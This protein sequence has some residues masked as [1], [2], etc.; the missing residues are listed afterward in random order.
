M[1]LSSNWSKLS[2]TQEKRVKKA[3]HGKSD[4]KSDGKTA[5]VGSRASGTPPETAQRRKS[6]AKT[7]KIMEMVAK[8]N[9][10]MANSRQNSAEKNEVQKGALEEKIS[11]D[12]AQ[13]GKAGKVGS[14][15]KFVAMD[16]EFVGVGPDGKE[17]VL[18]RV[19]VVN[20]YG[21]EVL[22]L[23]VRPKEK[24]TDWRTWV[25]GITPAHMKQA[26]TLEEAQRR[27]AAMLKNRVLIGHGL[28]HDLEMLMVSH[29]KAQIR[30]TSMHGPFRE[31]Y[32]AGKTPSLK[33]LARE[34]LN[35]DIQGKEHSSVEDA[36]AAL[37]LYKSDKVE[38]ERL[39]QQRFSRRKA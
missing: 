38:F 23:Y 18:A 17:S 30:D 15:G 35:I 2:K 7:S 13:S 24:V 21:Q 4:G 34:V 3:E 28:H 33:K 14:V 16:C 27:V 31:K 11:V 20:Y 25:S 5:G 1:V 37:L 36:R 32:G 10:E 8:M 19:S 29:P 26:V 39:H 22:D 9:R 12:M 6:K